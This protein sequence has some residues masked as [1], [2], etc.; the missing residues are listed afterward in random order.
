MFA[1]CC[2]C[3][4]AV[5]WFDALCAVAAGMALQATLQKFTS[6]D[7]KFVAVLPFIP[8]YNKSKHNK[9]DLMLVQFDSGF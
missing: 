2:F 3:C 5:L 6:A 9:L 8:F 1:D 7:N 4:S